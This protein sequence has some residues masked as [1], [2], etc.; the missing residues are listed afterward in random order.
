MTT[1][2]HTMTVFDGKIGYL[3]GKIE[4]VGQNRDGLAVT[5]DG[6][7]WSFTPAMARAWGAQLLI[8]ADRAEGK[9]SEE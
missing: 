7:R 5:L 8:V 2:K 3:Q 4:L 1:A 9:R 6:N